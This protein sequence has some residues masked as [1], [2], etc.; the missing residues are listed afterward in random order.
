MKNHP[1]LF[2]H[3]SNDARKKYQFEDGFYSI[4]G[5]LI[6]PDGKAARILTEKIK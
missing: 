5:N 6:I 3:V 2:F 1:E 4:R